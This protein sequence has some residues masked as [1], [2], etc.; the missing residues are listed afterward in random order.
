MIKELLK[1]DFGLD[2][3]IAGGTGK[4]RNDPIRVVSLSDKAA[5]RTEFLVL[6]PTLT[7]FS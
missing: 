6:S 4:S 3:D 1:R 7:P 2:L 5:S